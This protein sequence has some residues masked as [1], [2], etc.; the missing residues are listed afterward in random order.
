MKKLTQYVG[1]DVHKDSIS[2]AVAVEGRDPA[3]QLSRIPNDPT[4]LLKQLDRLGPRGQ[5]Q[6]CYEAGPTGYGLSRELKKAGI[7][8]VVVAPSLIPRKPGDRVKTDKRDAAKLA[9]FLRSGD[10]TNV[11]IPDESTEALRDLVRARDDAKLVERAARHRLSKFLLRQDR[12][13]PGRTAWTGMHL[14][15]I[16]SQSFEHEAQKR[17]LREYLHSVEDATSQVARLTK[18]I[19]ELVHEEDLGPLVTCLQALKGFQLV[20]S[21]GVAVEIGDLHRF[22]NPR[23][24]M[25]YLG[26]VPSEHSTG[27]GKRRGGI[28]KTGNKHV[29]RLLVEAAWSYRHPPKKSYAITK[30]WEG[31]APEVTSIAWKAQNRLHRR[32]RRLLGRG[33]SKQVVITALARELAGFVWAIGKQINKTAA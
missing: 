24:L 1:L 17:V 13:Y 25:A 5:L 26:L 33:K 31:V 29:R 11:R 15:W 2:I 27:D 20:T 3:Q 14:T 30:R 19:E 4:R 18:D 6:V 21:A 10:L 28:T 7:S 12:K 9:H 22:A 8:C 23:Q 16:R 32:Y